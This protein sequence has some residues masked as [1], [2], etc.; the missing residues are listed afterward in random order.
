MHDTIEKV[1]LD[2]ADVLN[3]EH[4]DRPMNAPPVGLV[5]KKN[6][7]IVP[8]KAFIPRRNPLHLQASGAEYVE[9]LRKKAIIEDVPVG[10]PTTGWLLDSFFV[11]RPH[12][13]KAHLIIDASPL[14]LV[15]ERPVTGFSSASKV[16]LQVL[17]GLCWWC[18]FDLK[19]AYF[20]V[21][22]NKEAKIMCTF[23]TEKGRMRCLRTPMGL[24]VSSDEFLAR[25]YV[26][27]KGIPKIVMLIDDILLQAESLPELMFLSAAGS[28]MYLLASLRWK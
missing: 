17:P 13:D 12:S 27:F 20:C 15:I 11:E 4:M 3:N 1:K 28:T 7:N 5:L 16:L 26:I 2:Y 8:Y 18:R 23:L 25:C 19:D 14:N 21:A 9:S 10:A 24:S 22:L 6:I